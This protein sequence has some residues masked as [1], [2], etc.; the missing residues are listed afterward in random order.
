VTGESLGQVSTQTLRNL[1]VAE[2]AAGVP[3]LR[4]LIGMDKQEILDRARMIGTHEASER[5]REHCQISTGRVETAARL[6]DVL[7]AEGRVDESFIAAAVDASTAVDL[8]TWAPGPPPDHVVESVPKGALVV[9]VRETEEG[10]SVGDLSLPFSRSAEWAPTLDPRND[11]VFVC[12]EGVRSETV[13][14]DLRRRGLRAYS[15]AGGIG[16]LHTPA[17]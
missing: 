16:S 8:V 6:R 3:V 2:E 12:T 10:P 1:A 15:L 13:A 9:D 5:V 4:P 7:T 11:Y 17:A 14:H